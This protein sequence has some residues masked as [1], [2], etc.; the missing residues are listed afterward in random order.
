[1]GQLL[2]GHQYGP[3][4]CQWRM[5]PPGFDNQCP[6][7]WFILRGRQGLRV[8]ICQAS[9]EAGREKDQ[10]DAGNTPSTK[11]LSSRCG[12]AKNMTTLLP[13]RM[14]SPANSTISSKTPT[15]NHEAIKSAIPA[16][17]RASST[18]KTSP[19][20]S[21]PIAKT[22]TS[23]ATLACSPKLSYYVLHEVFRC[24]I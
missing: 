6:R 24:H 7:T 21:K 19:Q 4:F 1:M 14:T 16:M 13:S 8:H 18:T 23:P 12:L 22:K 3:C 10:Q 15:P 5:T 9:Q 17:L 2:D 11:K 20:T